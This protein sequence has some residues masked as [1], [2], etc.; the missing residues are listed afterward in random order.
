MPFSIGLG[1][2]RH[3]CSVSISVLDELV[4]AVPGVVGFVL[5]QVIIDSLINGFDVWLNRM[6][7]DI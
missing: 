6:A 1:C 5:G 7:D 4:E 2:A 3:Q